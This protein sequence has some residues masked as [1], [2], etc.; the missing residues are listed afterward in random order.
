MSGQEALRLPPGFEA[1]HYLFSPS[2]VSVR[3]FA[4]VVQTFMLAMLEAG[5]NLRFSGSTRAKFVRHNNTRRAP[6]L[7]KLEQKSPVGGLVSPGL[8]QN[9]EDVTI[10]IDRAPQ[11]MGLAFETDDNLVEMPFVGRRWPI[12]PDFGDE[13]VAKAV[14][15][16]ADCLVGNHDTPFRQKILDVAQ[17]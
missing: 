17:V 1:P 15:L 7:Q 16:F 12:T 5:C 8:D 14:H 9:V 3:C 13:P 6:T 11:P 4:P 10:R 2:G